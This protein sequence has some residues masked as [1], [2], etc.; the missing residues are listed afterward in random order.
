MPK[1]IHLRVALIV[2]AAC[3]LVSLLPGTAAAGDDNAFQADVPIAD[4][5]A[6]ARSAAFDKAFQD[7]LHNVAGDDAAHMAADA[8]AAS[9][10]ADYQYH[11]AGDASAKPLVLTVTFA[12]GAIRHL[13]NTAGLATHAN[14]DADAGA[15]TAAM[16]MPRQTYSLRIAGLH[17]AGDFARAL[18]ALQDAG[19]VD[20]AQ[21]RG[22]DGDAIVIDVTSRLSVTALS[23]ELAA[24]GDFSRSGGNGS[25]ATDAGL[26]WGG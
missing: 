21:V 9:Y 15:E 10:V 22:A 23:S 25:G 12:P 2:V 17:S 14:E 26:V 19:H 1:S 7:V 3:V 20:H 8:D 4:T 16:N 13:T 18:S 11:R 24:N 5:S 6:Q